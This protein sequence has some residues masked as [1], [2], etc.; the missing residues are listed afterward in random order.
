M[1]EDMSDPVQRAKDLVAGDMVRFEQVLQ[2]TL[3]PQSPYLTETEYEIYRRGKKLR[4]L[5]LLLSARLASTDPTGELPAKAI[6]AAVSLE[7][8]HVATLIHD[9][10]I[11]VAPVRRG[12]RTVFSER[13]TEMAVL[14]GDMQFIQAI[15]CFAGG[16]DAQTDMHLVLLVLDVGFR[17]CCGE[18]DEIMTDPTQDVH[19]LEHRYLETVDRKTAAL[20]ALACESGASLVGAGKRTSFFL[21]RFGRQF[22]KAFQIMDDILDL[23]H[24]EELAG[25]AP[26]TDL[27]QGRLTLPVIYALPELPDDHLVRR[28][29]KKEQP[30]SPEELQQA[31]DAV[32]QSAGLLKAYSRARKFA[33]EAADFLTEF[34]ESPYRDALAEIAQYVVD[35]DITPPEH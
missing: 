18:L 29:M 17:I 35:R 7:M 19:S 27:L 2:E 11:D 5:M 26:G 15:R 4:P 22:G 34:P 10:I 8:L 31:V 33:L 30:G 9:D 23:V 20:F 13:G 25:K 28:M 6:K 16:I 3:E 14:I 32:V 24:P 1:K 21:G 12:L